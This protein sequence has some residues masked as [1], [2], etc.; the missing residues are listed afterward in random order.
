[1]VWYGVPRAFPGCS[2]DVSGPEVPAFRG[3]LRLGPAARPPAK[4]PLAVP[5]RRPVERCAASANRCRLTGF[6][7]LSC[8]DRSPCAATVVPIAPA[9]T[10]PP[11]PGAVH[12]ASHQE[13]RDERH[14]HRRAGRHGFRHGRQPS[15]GR[16]QPAWLRPG[17]RTTRVAGTRGRASRRRRG[18]G[19][20]TF[21]GRLRHGA[22]RG[23]GRGT[24]P[25]GRRGSR[26]A[27][28]RE[29]SFSCRPP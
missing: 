18:G 13:Y 10:R 3:A 7:A 15:A 29:G 25:S 1:M 9:R 11:L 8:A 19:R 2:A 5:V 16:F 17:P 21:R 24:R 23:P 26:R 4:L 22:E 27:W 20:T 12:R 14:R 28:R 6:R